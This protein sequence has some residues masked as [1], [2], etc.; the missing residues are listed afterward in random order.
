[1]SK[2]KQRHSKKGWCLPCHIRD[3]K[4]QWEGHTPSYCIEMETT[5]CG[6]AT[7][8]L[9]AESRENA[10]ITVKNLVLE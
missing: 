9:K 4:T 8:L 10:K 6:P 7:F 1:V 2:L 5:H 3:G